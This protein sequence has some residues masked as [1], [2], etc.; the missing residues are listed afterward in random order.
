MAR[1]IRI[2][3]LSFR[4]SLHG[5]WQ[6][7]SPFLTSLCTD[8]ADSSHP[9]FQIRWNMER[10]DRETTGKRGSIGVLER[11]SCH[12]IDSVY[13]LFLCLILETQI[14]RVKTIASENIGKMIFD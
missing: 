4:L 9:V 7:F 11:F 14:E 3:I 8:S 13:L 12:L 10:K 6:S 1:E 2:G 5:W